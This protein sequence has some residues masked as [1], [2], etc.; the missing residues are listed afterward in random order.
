MKIRQYWV[1]KFEYTLHI[2]G[3]LVERSP[4]GHPITILTHHAPHLPAGL[5]A[6]LMGKKPGDYLVNLPP[7]SAYGPYDLAK[8]VVVQRRELPEE[9]RLGGAFTAQGSDGEPLLYRVVEIAGDSVTLDANPKWAGKT[10]EYRLTIHTVRPADKDEIAHGHVH[11]E[12]G[13]IHQNP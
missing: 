13:V 9:P 5:E 4:E 8:R 10:L 3:A 2:D 11:G 12:G 6:L 1:I 7:E